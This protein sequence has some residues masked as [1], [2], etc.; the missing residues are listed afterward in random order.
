MNNRTIN[1]DSLDV[2]S[3]N[4]DEF[5][6][7]QISY[8]KEIQHRDEEL[9]EDF[10]FDF[11]KWTSDDFKELSKRNEEFYEVFYEIMVF[12]SIRVIRSQTV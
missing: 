9:W 8:Y 10:R 6:E 11:A 4:Y 5:I 1:E 2:P 7:D 3:E 12:I